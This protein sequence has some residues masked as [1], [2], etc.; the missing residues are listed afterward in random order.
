MLWVVLSLLSLVR[1]DFAM[2]NGI[3]GEPTVIHL[4]FDIPDRILDRL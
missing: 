3:V 4:V 1:A 2:E